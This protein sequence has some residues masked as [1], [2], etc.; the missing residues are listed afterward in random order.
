MNEDLEHL[1]LLSIFHYVVA[2]IGALFACFPCFH[3]AFGLILAITPGAIEHGTRGNP[4]IS[5]FI[6]A[7]MAGI[8]GVM[9][10]AGWTLALCVFL[11]ARFLAVQRNYTFCLVIACILCIMVPFGTVLGV[12]T[13]IVLMRPSVKSLFNRQSERPIADH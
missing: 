4:E 1:R 5:Q 9:I 10:L 12:F 3:L 13:I 6:G 8:A 11:S 2:G 7:M